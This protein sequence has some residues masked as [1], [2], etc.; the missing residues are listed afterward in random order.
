MK[1]CC[2][3]DTHGDKKII[4]EPHDVT[5]FAGDWTSLSEDKYALAETPAFLHWF[6]SLSPRQILVAGNHD[7]VPARHKQLFLDILASYPSITYLEDTE[8]VIDGVKF[9]GS[10]YTPIFGDWYFTASEYSL[11]TIFSNIPTDTDILITHGP[12]HSVLDKVENYVHVGSTA[13]LDVI[14]NLHIIS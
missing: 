12:A 8:L 4:T 11:S 5:I 13:L 7:S 1:L 3:S 14:D 9:Y 6:A 2:F 10:P